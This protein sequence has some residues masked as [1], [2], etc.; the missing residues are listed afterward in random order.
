[1]TDPLVIR[2]LK[3]FRNALLAREDAQLQR[4][5]KQ[6]L[7]MEQSLQVDMQVL[8]Q[9]LDYAKQ[10]GL[11]VTEQ[12]IAKQAEY[13]RLEA[14]LHDQVL[15]YVR[16]HAVADIAGEQLAY[17]EHGIKGA[18]DAIKASYVNLVP[19]FNQLPVD[20]L[21]DYIGMLGDGTPL[22]RLLKEAY[23]DALDGIVKALL[24]GMARGLGPRQIAEDM[25]HGMGLG[26]ERITTIA[27]TE[28][29]RV[30]RVATAKQYQESK[31]VT[32]SRRLATHDSRVCPAC[33]FSD[34]E[35]VP[36]G[37]VLHDHPRGRCTS[38]PEVK[39][40]PMITWQLGKDWFLHQGDSIQHEILGPK[41]FNLWKQTG[42]DLTSLVGVS[43]SEVWGDSPRVKTLEEM[44]NA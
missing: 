41:M 26:L 5:A 9:Q 22:Y 18:V 1:M 7:Q 23:P 20:A 2:I 15:K 42:F 43:K 38:V 21:S 31:V 35:V 24:N 32:R 29:L 11:V 28:Q 13:Q 19:T 16:D 34:G 14:Q 8:A 44:Q 17:A 30:W 27:R 37:E 36:L 10:H 25:S 40:A 39:G 3:E 33:L 12:L 4:M 6:W